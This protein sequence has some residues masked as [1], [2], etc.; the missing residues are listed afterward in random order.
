MVVEPRPANRA[1]ATR[2][3]EALVDQGQTYRMIEV[4]GTS[5][6]SIDEAI[7]NGI[8]DAGKDG[9]DLN[10]FEV[11]EIRG[12]IDDDKVGWYQVRM[13]VGSRAK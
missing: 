13:A 5:P 8:A 3:M 12:Y 10:W 2:W 6:S 1:V 11:R 4:V 9:G 7:Q